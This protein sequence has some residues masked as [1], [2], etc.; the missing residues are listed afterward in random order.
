MPTGCDSGAAA[1]TA[2]PAGTIP[3]PDGAATTD[4][5]QP[6]S[7]QRTE[8]SDSYVTEDEDPGGGSDDGAADSGQS[9]G[10][11][12]G[13]GSTSAHG[14]GIKGQRRAGGR[15]KS[16]ARGDGNNKPPVQG[17]PPV[18]LMLA[19][20]PG[21]GKS[22][23]SRNLQESSAVSWVH[24]NQDAI[25]KGKPG[26]RE[27][28]VAAVRAALA[29]GSCCIIDRCHLDASQRDTFL[30]LAAECAVAPHCVALAVPAKECAA[31]VAA[32][33]DHPGGVQGDRNKGVVYRMARQQQDGKGWP[34]AAGEGFVSVM[35][36]LTDN[37]TNAAVRAWA[38]YG[39]A[40]AAAGGAANTANAPAQ[41]AA[42]L[43]GNSSSGS[44]AATQP[45]P[46]AHSA[47]E[48]Q[49][50]PTLAMWQAHVAKRKPPVAPPS[51]TAFF[52]PEAAK[53]AAA[54]GA[55]ATTRTA[56]GA[57]GVAGLAGRAATGGAVA[58][59]ASKAAA[60]S[61]QQGGAA[62]S[63]P[64][65][66]AKAAAGAGAAAARPRSADSSPGEQRPAKRPAT[67]SAGSAP[68]DAGGGTPPASQGPGSPP[69]AGQA[70]KQE[71]RAGSQPSSGNGSTAAAGSGVGA[72]AFAV[73]M[74]GSRQAAA[75]AAAAAA[76][77]A[78]P[79]AT[80]ALR[81]GHGGAGGAGA[82]GDRRF[83]LDSP[84]AQALRKTALDP[85]GSQQQVLHKDEQV[86][87]IMDA[88]PKARNHAL[89]IARDPALRS[90]ADLRAA[91]VPLLEHMRQVAQAWVAKRREQVPG[92]AAFKLGFH[93]VPS[94]CQLH[95][96]VISQDFDSPAL[97]NKKH[98][99]TF[100]TEFFL[101]LEAV[102][103]ELASQGRIALISEAE[104][105]RLEGLEL[106]CHACGRPEKTIPALKSHIV[107]CDAVKRMPGL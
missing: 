6:L 77:G 49:A 53:T 81:A 35:E 101:P 22:T 51:I 9:G 73:L 3:G 90:I 56:P 41:A 64:A 59:A 44:T 33:T 52:K 106:R 83:K 8:A 48:A 28:C 88:F 62:K 72:N 15:S 1:G 104:E 61:G 69:S 97:K 84:W 103:A 80:G 68:G 11:G 26:K 107:A 95:L 54:P 79:G 24:V 30:Q 87:M 74:K 16:A 94:M 98:W 5:S 75:V 105:K 10:T 43:A 42:Q 91:H 63:A 102:L 18:L 29:E 70:S 92:A 86:V 71:A 76:A 40:A 37:D 100:T 34:P 78:K 20:L 60:A 45:A 7:L 58:G 23:F 31:R 2:A 66:G 19:G 82:D 99:N 57:A 50:A 32:R 14:S 13:P 96:H 55:A 27:Q 89:V 38:A 85:D 21:S 93:A 12:P 25:N 67:A 36:C 46:A 65:A 47:A 4:A 39:V 17:L